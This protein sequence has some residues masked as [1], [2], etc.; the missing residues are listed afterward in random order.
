M[1]SAKGVVQAVS[2]GGLQF[3]ITDPTVAMWAEHSRAACRSRSS[4]APRPTRPSRSASSPG[5]DRVRRR[6]QPGDDCRDR[7]GERRG[8]RDGG[9]ARRGRRGLVVRDLEE[10]AAGLRSPKALAGGATA[11]SRT[12]CALQ[13]QVARRSDR[14]DVRRGCAAER[15]DLRVEG[16]QRNDQEVRHSPSRRQRLH[17]EAEAVGS[18]PSRRPSATTA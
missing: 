9:L 8:A 6:S 14:V 12:S 2:G 11:V 7:Q 15:R 17:D 13:E 16:E 1:S 18:R 4:R 3:G 10:H 5:P